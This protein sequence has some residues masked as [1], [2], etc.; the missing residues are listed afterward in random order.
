LVDVGAFLQPAAAPEPPTGG[1]AAPWWRSPALAVALSH[2]V[3]L[4]LCACAAATQ[5]PFSHWLP[6]AAEFFALA[7]GVTATASPPRQVTAAALVTEAMLVAW[8]AHGTDIS[9]APFMPCLLA[10][11][12]TTGLL[13]GGRRALL[14]AGL[15]IAVL[16]GTRIANAGGE[17]WPYF[18][19][20]AS[21]WLVLSAVVGVLPDW[22]RRLQRPSDGYLD[23][24]YGEALDLLG[25]LHAVTRRLPGSLEPAS[26]AEAVLDDCFALATVDSAA[27]LVDVGDGQLVPLA[28]RG[29]SRVP[30]RHPLHSPGPLR[31]AWQEGHA[32]LDVREPDQVGRRQG[33]ALLGIPLLGEDDAAHALVVLE[34]RSP[35]GFPAD[36]VARLTDHVEGNSLRLRTAMSFDALRA[37]AGVEE[38]ER[39]AREMHDGVAQDL[40]AVGFALDLLRRRA[41]AADQQFGDEVTA[42]RNQVTAMIS[43]LRLSITDL[44]GSVSPTRGLGAALSGYLHTA[45][46]GTGLA[47]HLSLQ[48]SAFRLPADTEMEL[49]RIAQELIGAARRAGAANLWVDLRVEPPGAELAVAHDAPDTGTPDE[50]SL[51]G[52]RAERVGGQLLSDV[53]PAIG[54]R[55]IVTVHGGRAA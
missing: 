29:T 36:T 55:T 46:A 26:V 30:W 44:R 25:Q 1:S 42:L 45:G 16:L 31:D 27:V 12:F 18:A 32:V 52:A 2:A 11:A 19:M 49:L 38:R 24:R 14:I 39:L 33:S 23:A 50:L 10:V 9:A 6:V 53:D 7:V 37:A 21:T 4:M 54:V 48:E 41:E 8:S 13:L 51:L 34:S 28:V 5:R 3:L 47:V 22:A 43:D 35:S 40:V 20:Q 17:P 15:A